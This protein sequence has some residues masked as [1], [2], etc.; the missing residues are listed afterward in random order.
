MT[1]TL[2]PFPSVMKHGIPVTC[3]A[4]AKGIFTNKLTNDC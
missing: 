4:D 3:L 1:M 2:I